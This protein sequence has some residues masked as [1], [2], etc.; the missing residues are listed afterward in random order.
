MS[1]KSSAVGVFQKHK[2]EY[3]KKMEQNIPKAT[4]TYLYNIPPHATRI[5]EHKGNIAPFCMPKQ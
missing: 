3:K 4:E 5:E 1:K 2:I